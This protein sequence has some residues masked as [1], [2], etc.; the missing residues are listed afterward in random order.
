MRKFCIQMLGPYR[1]V[2]S[3]YDTTANFEPLSGWMPLMGI[4]NV[5]FSV[6]VRN[7]A[8]NLTARPGYQVANVRT[9]RPS[10][11]RGPPPT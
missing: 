7:L 10:R 9:T 4:D 11:P 2:L 6:D 5:D 3:A 1:V 8:G